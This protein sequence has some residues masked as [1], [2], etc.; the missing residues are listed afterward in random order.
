MRLH[1]INQKCIL[2]V[3]NCQ[4]GFLGSF[5]YNFLATENMGNVVETFH[6]VS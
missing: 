2:L 5:E 4:G 3:V 1:E 6:R